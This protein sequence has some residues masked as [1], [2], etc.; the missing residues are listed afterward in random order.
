MSATIQDIVRRHKSIAELREVPFE[1]K[2]FANG[3]AI[4]LNDTHPALAIVELFRILI[5]EEGVDRETAWGIVYNT[6]SYT[7]HTIMP[8]ALE[9]WTVH[10]MQRLLPRHL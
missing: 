8:E 2:D 4:Q 7:N 6:F 10:L 1:W 3:A 5:D 9:K